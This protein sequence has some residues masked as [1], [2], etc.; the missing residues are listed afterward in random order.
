MDMLHEKIYTRTVFYGTCRST[1][2]QPGISAPE[3]RYA[4]TCAASARFHSAA[5]TGHRHMW[6]TLLW[7]LSL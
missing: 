3:K 6:V 7:N 1:F 2:R 5:T 4:R